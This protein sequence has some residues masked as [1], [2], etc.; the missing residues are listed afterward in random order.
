M[1]VK[2]TDPGTEGSLENNLIDRGRR[3]A[4][5]RLGLAAAAV[6]TAPT[7]LS[8]T[9]ARASSSSGG[10]NG[11]SSGGGNSGPSGGGSSGPSGNSDPTQPSAA[12]APTS[13]SSSDSDEPPI[14][15]DNGS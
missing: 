1:D 11:G 8:L 14:L 9:P 2:H 15:P 4:L 12:S 10:G 3:R 6:Y 5:A 7:L 13:P